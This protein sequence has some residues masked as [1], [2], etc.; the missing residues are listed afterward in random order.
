M[1]GGFPPQSSSSACS[2]FLMPRNF[3]VEFEAPNFADGAT[4]N[5]DI[6]MKSE[7]SSLFQ[8]ATC[9]NVVR[10]LVLF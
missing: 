8:T 2:T 9:N 3:K 4:D 1:A 6:Q 7:I 5:D 10:Q